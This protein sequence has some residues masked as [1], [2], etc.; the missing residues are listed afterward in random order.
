MASRFDELQWL[1]GNEIQ[2]FELSKI[3]SEMDVVRLYIYLFDRAL[4]ENN[5]KKSPNKY[6]ICKEIAVHLVQHRKTLDGNDVVLRPQH[7]I[8]QY[9][10]RIIDRAEKLKFSLIKNTKDKS[11]IEAKKLSFEDLVH[12]VKKP[13]EAPPHSPKRK[14]EEAFG[15]T[16]DT[17]VITWEKL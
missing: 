3:P 8:N 4:S 6:D 1:A 9:V 12:V 16:E 15:F 2:S 11:Q 7:Y 5:M 17:E 10:K 13:T 14:L